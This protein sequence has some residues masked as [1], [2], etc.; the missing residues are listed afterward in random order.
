MSLSNV[1]GAKIIHVISFFLVRVG[2][3]TVFYRNERKEFFAFVAVIR[4][5]FGKS[6]SKHERCSEFELQIS[7]DLQPHNFKPYTPLTPH[8][9]RLTILTPHDPHA[10]R[11]TFLASHSI[12][13][14]TL[15]HSLSF[16]LSGIK[17]PMCPIAERPRSLG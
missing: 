2:Y 12:Q 8:D 5:R 4:S 1:A 15:S 16:I 6:L 3:A 7:A 9:S 14:T 11:L 13:S 10:S 17:K